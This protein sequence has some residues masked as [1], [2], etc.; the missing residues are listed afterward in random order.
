MW[1]I[2]DPVFVDFAHFLTQPLSNWNICT[3]L[4]LIG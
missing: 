3:Q 2:D 4:H 1:T